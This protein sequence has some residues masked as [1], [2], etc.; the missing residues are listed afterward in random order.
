MVASG[1]G[2]RII[3]VTS[4]HERLPLANALAYTAAKHALGGVVKVLALE[5]A[6]HGATVNAVA[7]GLI[8]TAMGGIDE[9]ASPHEGVSG[10]RASKGRN[11]TRGCC[12]HPIPG[13]PGIVLR[14]RLVLCR[15][16]RSGSHPRNRTRHR[17]SA[18]L[19]VAPDT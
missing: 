12:G 1:Q 11:C 7:S 16:R 19:A 17:A 2:G 4:I 18:P 3:V 6:S 10:H 5:L 14:H 9:A 8:A 13:L 15:R